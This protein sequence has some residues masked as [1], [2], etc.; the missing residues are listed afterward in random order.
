MYCT[1]HIFLIVF[2][3]YIYMDDVLSEIIFLLLLKYVDYSQKTKF[4][5]LICRFVHSCGAGECDSGDRHRAHR[6]G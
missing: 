4:S 5:H 6:G 3:V 1:F 2:Y